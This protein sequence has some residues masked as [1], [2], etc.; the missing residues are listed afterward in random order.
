MASQARRMSSLELCGEMHETGSINTN[1]AAAKYFNTFQDSIEEDYFDDVESIQ[2]KF[3]DW[4][5]FMMQT[6]HQERPVD[7]KTTIYN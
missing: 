5:Q 3:F 7:P 1:N 6:P 2:L 4:V